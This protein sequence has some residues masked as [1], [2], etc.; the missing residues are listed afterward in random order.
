M[1]RATRAFIQQ[2]KASTELDRLACALRAYELTD[3]RA[4]VARKEAQV[5]KWEHE[6]NHARRG[7]G[8]AIRDADVVVKNRADV[9]TQRDR[10]LKKSGKFTRQ[11]T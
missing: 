7:K 8:R 10:E 4:K 3:H 5:A 1:C 11:G 2:R 9:H 6:V